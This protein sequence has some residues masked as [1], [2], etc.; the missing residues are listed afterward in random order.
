M[1]STTAPA[2]L[3]VSLA[4]YCLI[5]LF[6]GHIEAV[7][8]FQAVSAAPTAHT[9]PPTPRPLPLLSLLS[10]LLPFHRLSVSNDVQQVRSCIHARYRSV[11]TT[12]PRAQLTCRST[13][14]F[15]P[16]WAAVIDTACC[17]VFINT[18]MTTFRAFVG[19]VWR[20]ASV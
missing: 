6:S 12:P 14:Q 13:R 19:C 16:L 3:A 18:H 17:L 7:L 8:A 1:K 11:L 15:L 5:P 2:S 4:L 9:A 20:N 10:L